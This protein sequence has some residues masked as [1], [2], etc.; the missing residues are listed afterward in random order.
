MA[1]SKHSASQPLRR[2]APP[3]G[4]PSPAR[5]S[6][7][8]EETDSEDDPQGSY[9]STSASSSPTPGQ[10]PRSQRVQVLPSQDE[11]DPRLLHLNKHV[12]LRDMPRPARF[13]TERPLND[14]T[15]EDQEEIVPSPVRGAVKG[16]RA[17]GIGSLSAK[18][19]LIIQQ[20]IPILR[21]HCLRMVPFQ[22][23][24]PQWANT[25]HEEWN[26]ASLELFPDPEPYRAPG[27]DDYEV[28]ARGT[29]LHGRSL[30]AWPATIF[31]SFTV[32]RRSGTCSTA[33]F[34]LANSSRRNGGCATRKP[35]A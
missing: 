26:R 12:V 1:L 7:P 27:P 10:P 16:R 14:A 35:D 6:S 24:T 33:R 20:M 34:T 13:R 31:W 2:P 18:A 22:A 29:V 30:P 9:S 5:D 11:E 8:T 32:C 25:L 4:A 28:N 15:D 21:P 17:R 19:Q 3:P 23:W